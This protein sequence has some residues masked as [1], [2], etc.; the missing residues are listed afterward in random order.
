MKALLGNLRFIVTWKIWAALVVFGAG[1]AVGVALCHAA[2]DGTI[3]KDSGQRV[4]GRPA[5][6]VLGQMAPLDKSSEL[7]LQRVAAGAGQS[8]HFA[9]AHPAVVA[10]VIENA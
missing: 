9:H 3:A 1:I 6:A 4:P 7:L 2:G 5:A 8:D 10:G